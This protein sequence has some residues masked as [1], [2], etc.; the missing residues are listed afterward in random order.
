MYIAIITV[1]IS[2]CIVALWWAGVT[3]LSISGNVVQVPLTG[4]VTA[5]AADGLDVY[6]FSYSSAG[7]FIYSAAYNSSVA[8]SAVGQVG[9]LVYPAWNKRVTF[10]WTRTGSTYAYV[11]MVV[12]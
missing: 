9:Y 1:A 8:L 12:S 5:A 7:I 3:P 2:I 10:T 11:K 4:T 6:R